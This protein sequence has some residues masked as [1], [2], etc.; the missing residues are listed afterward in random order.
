[1]MVR[2][3]IRRENGSLK[4]RFETLALLYCN[5]EKVVERKEQTETWPHWPGDRLGNVSM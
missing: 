4:V 3:E 2:E 1:M 5:G